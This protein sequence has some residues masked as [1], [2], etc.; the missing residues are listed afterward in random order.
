MKNVTFL[1]LATLCLFCFTAC[2]KAADVVPPNNDVNYD[3][4]NRILRVQASATAPYVV[5]L[6]E[7]TSSSSVYNTQIANQT[8]PFD[9]GWTPGIG[10]TVK[11][12]IKS[13]TGRISAKVLYN[14]TELDPVT[15]VDVSGGGST[16][17]YSYTV[18]K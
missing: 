18:S 6:T 5:T 11:V 7:L 16:A 9:Y 4:H 8:G 2:K 10:N 1:V 12:S 3:L 14:G 17:D 15:I 13:N